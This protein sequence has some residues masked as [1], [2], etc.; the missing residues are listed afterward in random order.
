MATVLNASVVVSL[1][2][3][4]I[5]SS[6][7]QLPLLL[8]LQLQLLLLSLFFLTKNT[9]INTTTTVIPSLQDH[10]LIST[11]TDMNTFTIQF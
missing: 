5:Y 3:L 10:L 6:L 8:Q 4:V 1:V 9:S 7:Q 11:F 2:E